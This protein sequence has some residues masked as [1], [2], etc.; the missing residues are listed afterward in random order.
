MAKYLLDVGDRLL[1]HTNPLIKGEIIRISEHLGMRHYVI[2]ITT[3]GTA[4]RELSLSETGTLIKF[5][6]D[7]KTKK[8]R[9]KDISE[10]NSIAR[11]T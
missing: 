5:S 3:P 11:N 9:E 7:P 8:P 2:R 4:P 6:V 1:D 10:K